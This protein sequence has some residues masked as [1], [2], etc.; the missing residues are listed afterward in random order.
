MANLS[1]FVINTIRADE[2]IGEKQEKCLIFRLTKGGI[3]VIDD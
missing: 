2:N 3:F 1:F